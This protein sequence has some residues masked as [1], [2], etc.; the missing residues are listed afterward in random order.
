M[1]RVLNAVI[2]SVAVL[3]GGGMLVAGAVFVARREVDPVT[4][5]MIGGLALAVFEG[6]AVALR[7]RQVRPTGPG[8]FGERVLMLAAVE[9]G[10]IAVALVVSPAST[11]SGGSIVV[12]AVGLVALTTLVGAQATRRA[13]T[14]ASR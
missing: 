1:A 9:L 2:G 14:R 3:L 8:T 7:R 5:A 13:G 6:A 4:A 12:G 10:A 11:P